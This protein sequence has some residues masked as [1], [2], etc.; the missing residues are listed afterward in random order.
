MHA[1]FAELVMA[2]LAE[3][4]AQRR[5]AQNQG[6]DLNRFTGE[7]LGARRSSVETNFGGSEA[8]VPRQR[9]ANST[10][11]LIAV[12]FKIQSIATLELSAAC[13]HRYSNACLISASSKAL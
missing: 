11:W 4:L 1:L 8:W 5:E 6:L 13:C 12:P 7:E 10:G 2:S 3:L 9:A